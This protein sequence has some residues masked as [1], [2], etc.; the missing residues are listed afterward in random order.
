[1]DSLDV[2]MLSRCFFPPERRIAADVAIVF[3]MN[4]PERPVA[5][6]VAAF[7]A[8]L[9][10]RLLFTGGYNRRLGCAEGPEMARQAIANGVP[11]EAV[12]VEDQALHTEQNVEFACRLLENERGGR[13]GV[14]SVLIL[15]IEYHL[16]RACLAARRRLPED[17]DLGWTCYPSRHYGASNW[18]EVARGRTDVLG[19]LA[20]I[21]RYYGLTL[22]ELAG[23]AA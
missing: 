2:D 7:N 8:G 13:P 21:E 9:A 17:V 22:A 4:A 1:M 15:T 19:E 23:Q 6:A 11:A 18:F 5:H 10:R 14:G 3:G 16:R 20:R 12:L